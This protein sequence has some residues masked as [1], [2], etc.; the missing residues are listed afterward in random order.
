[1]IQSQ[2]GGAEKTGAKKTES[3]RQSQ[4]ERA[5]KK[6]LRRQSRENRAKKTAQKA[7]PEG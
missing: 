1:M 4:E 5:K 3:G 7:G 2:E 6:E